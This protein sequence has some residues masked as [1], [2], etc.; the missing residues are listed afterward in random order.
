[1]PNTASW[2]LNGSK[3][4]EFQYG[5]IVKRKAFRSV[6]EPASALFRWQVG[7]RNMHLIHDSSTQKTQTR[8]EKLNRNYSFLSVVYKRPNRPKTPNNKKNASRRNLCSL[9]KVVYHVIRPILVYAVG[10]ATI[11]HV[12]SICQPDYANSSK[13]PKFML[14]R[15]CMYSLSAVVS[16]RQK[17]AN[18]AVVAFV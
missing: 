2:V 10:I 17:N 1:M 7:C 6:S 4:P 14:K 18:D 16:E 5:H 3:L 9:P 11:K 12:A 8:L 13:I 15:L